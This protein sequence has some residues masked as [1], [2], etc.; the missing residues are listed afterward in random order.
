MFKVPNIFA[1][2]NVFSDRVIIFCQDSLVLKILFSH[3]LFGFLIF[4]S[5]LF[6][7]AYSDREKG[8]IV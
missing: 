1:K 5:F 6:N 4:I 3:H 8:N 2:C 7:S